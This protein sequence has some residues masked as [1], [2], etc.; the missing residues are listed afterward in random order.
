PGQA[1]A[2]KPGDI[3][4]QDLDCGPMCDAIE[5]VTEGA[6]GK[7]YSHCAMVIR[8]NDSLKVIE[9]IGEGVVVTSLQDF[10]RRSSKIQVARF[11]QAD[12]AFLQRA[13]RFAISLKGKPYDEVF[14]LNNDRYY[15]SELL[16]EAFKAA[17]YGK[18]VFEL[19]PMTFKEPNSHEYYPVWV[20]YYSKLKCPIPEGKP[21]LNPG[22]ISRSSKLELID[23]ILKP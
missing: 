18:A 4:F 9:A 3:V 22:G 2:L 10:V 6:N 23:V 11:K 19:S 16:Y 12:N 20:D 17:N 21:G 1:K 14:L 13:I 15:C 7:D 5:A 8:E